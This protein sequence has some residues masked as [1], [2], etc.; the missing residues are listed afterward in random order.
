MQ[1]L[2]Q[3]SRFDDGPL[4]ARAYLN[5]HGIPLVIEKH[6]PRTYLDG[7]AMKAPNGTPIVALTLRYDR[8]DNFW[9]TLMH[10]LAHVS[11]HLCSGDVGFFY[12]NLDVSLGNE[13]EQDADAL[14]NKALVP[15][16]AWLKLNLDAPLFAEDVAD[17]A[18]SLHIHPAILAGRIRFRLNNYRILNTLV[19][20]REVR[21][22]FD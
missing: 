2:A 3:L 20:H 14:A 12:D 9:F 4:R 8:L 19:G 6:L 17:L 21:K 10:E 16:D 15:E 13:Y 18:N 5:E 7:A 11:L 1:R 22:L